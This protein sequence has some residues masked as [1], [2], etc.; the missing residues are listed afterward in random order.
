MYQSGSDTIHTNSIPLIATTATTTIP[1]IAAIAFL[2]SACFIDTIASAYVSSLVCDVMPITLATPRIAAITTRTIPAIG[3]SAGGDGDRGSVRNAVTFSGVG[4][5]VLAGVSSRSDVAAD[6]AAG[7]ADGVGDGDCAGIG[8][9][10][11][12]PL[13][14]LPPLPSSEPSGSAEVAEAMMK[15][16]SLTSS[17]VLPPEQPYLPHSCGCYQRSGTAPRSAA[18]QAQARSRDHGSGG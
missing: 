15:S 2:H 3:E 16:P 14:L 17:P 10:S 4:V 13:L 18:C 5:V 11:P 6:S 12:P 9:Y 8:R 1:T 7:G